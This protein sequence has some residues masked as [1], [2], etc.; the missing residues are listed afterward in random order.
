MT[1]GMGQENGLPETK[2]G[3]IGWIIE[4]PDDP[5]GDYVMVKPHQYRE[6]LTYADYIKFIKPTPFRRRRDCP[7][8]VPS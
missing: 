2:S 7:K 4:N 3:L 5:Y 8:D 1:N 6:E